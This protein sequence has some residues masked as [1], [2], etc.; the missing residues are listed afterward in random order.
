MQLHGARGRG[1]EGSLL[2]DVGNNIKIGDDDP[3][4]GSTA[5]TLAVA[6]SDAPVQAQE[7]DTRSVGGIPSPSSRTMP[8]LTRMSSGRLGVVTLAGE[9]WNAEVSYR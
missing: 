3:A 4:V 2:L 9:G 6:G 5:E 1:P 8:L 7:E